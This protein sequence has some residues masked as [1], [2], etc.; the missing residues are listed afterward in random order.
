VVWGLGLIYLLIVSVFYGLGLWLPL[1]IKGAAPDASVL[2]RT[3]LVSL[4]YFL[5]VVAMVLLGRSSDRRGERRWHLV[6]PLLIGTAGLVATTAGGWLGYGGLTLAAVAINATLG[7]FWTVPASYLAGIGAAAGIALVN[8][9]GN[10]GGFLGP[11]TIGRLADPK[12][13]SRGLL[14][15]AGSSLLAAAGVWWQVRGSRSAGPTGRDSGLER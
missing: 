7:V 11:Y 1:I 5:A 6:V 9:I 12:G 13:Y 15:L 14:A 2:E 8:S 4:P 10:V 3:G